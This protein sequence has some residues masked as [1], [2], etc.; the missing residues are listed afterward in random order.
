MIIKLSTDLIIGALLLPN[1]M[2]PQLSL[3]C[4]YLQGYNYTAPQNIDEGV[5]YCET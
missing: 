4:L 3:Y 5:L 1:S 2:F